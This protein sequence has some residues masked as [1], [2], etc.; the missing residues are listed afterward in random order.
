MHVFKFGGTSIGSPQAIGQAASIASAHAGPLVVVVSAMAKVT[1]LLLTAVHSAHRGDRES[2]AHAAAQFRKSH[3][4]AVRELI[5][6]ADEKKALLSL[7]EDAAKELDAICQ[8][9]LVLRELTPR[10]LDTTVARGERTLAR[11]F[12]AVL[13]QRG[14]KAAYVDAT[15][16]VTVEN[17]AGTLFADWADCARRA[18][19]KILPLLAAGSVVIVPGFIGRTKDVDLV[20]LGRGGSD[21]SAAILAN[22]LDASAVTLYK[23]VDGLL[24]TDPRHVPQ[25]RLIRELHYREAAEL[26]YY[27]AKVLHPRTMIPLVDKRIVLTIKNTFHPELPGTRVAGD[28][29]VAE[30]PVKAL[31]AIVG[32]SLVAVEGK[33]MMGVPGVAG[34]TFSA[35]ASD[36]ISVTVIS[37][38]S[39]ESSICL[40]VPE[41]ESARATKVLEEAFAYEIRVGMIDGI[42]VEPHVAVVAV[43]G[44]GMRGTPGIAART[45]GALS[46]VPANVIA[47]AQGSSELNISVVVKEADVPASLRAL[48]DEFQLEKTHA[49]PVRDEREINV[50]LFGFG[51]IGRELLKQLLSQDAFI[52]NE[53]NLRWRCVA[54]ADR[55]GI[56]TAKAGHEP[57]VLEGYLEGKRAG[58]KLK[59]GGAHLSLPDALTELEVNLWQMP[60]GRAVFV[61]TTAEDTWSLL[62]E[63]LRAGF[64]VALANKKPLAVPQPKFDELMEEAQRRGLW[65]RYEATVGAGLPVLDTLSKLREA[66][67]GVLTILGCLS[68]TLGFLFSRLGQGSLFSQA[69]R[70]AHAA[71]YTEPDPRDDLNGVDVARKALILARTLGRKLDLE[72]IVIEPVVVGPPDDSVDQFMEKLPHHDALFRDR[73]HAADSKGMVLRYVARIG[74][75]HVRV[76][77]EEVPKAS[78]LGAL[79]GSANQVVIRTHRYDANPLIVTGPGAGADVTAAGVLN[80]VLAIAMGRDRRA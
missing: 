56:V 32:Q 22:A 61:D 78:S 49:L 19:E 29:P 33:G 34:R 50:A 73:V 25:A 9:V 28:V 27:G 44:L 6:S 68:G 4:D 58:E 59:K 63:A 14:T 2:M 51:Q 10:T 30:S 62:R 7:V 26:A 77:I 42:R 69:V 39:S 38:A 37:Q 16:V 70:E 60:L 35:L 31:T 18:T 11:I 80:D 21:F 41:A 57:E 8:S 65:L 3:A 74:E 46:K 71:G 76:G 20:T 40:V 47:I 12:C 75:K 36:S 5:A 23:E 13:S 54:L 15:E 52:R 66:G 67:D 53:M 45:F 72:D 1:D 43:V 55:S 64:H 48:H 24:T 79:E 17:R